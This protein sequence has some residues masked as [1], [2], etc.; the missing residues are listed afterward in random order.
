MRKAFYEFC[1]MNLAHSFAQNFQDLFALWVSRGSRSAYFVEFGALNGRDFSNTYL[2]EKLGWNGIV[3]EPNPAYTDKIASV[4]NCHISHDCVFEESG[5][6]VEFRQVL[7][8]AALSGIGKTELRDNKWEFRQNYKSIAIRTIS[9]NDLLAKYNA[10]KKIEF[11]SIDTE[12]SELS[13]L[14]SFDFSRWNVLS[15]CV[16][17]NSE[18]RDSI[19]SLM[20]EHGYTRVFEELSGHDDWWVRQQWDLSELP[21]IKKLSPE[22]TETFDK[23]LARRVRRL[24]TWHRSLNN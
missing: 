21:A 17:H 16:E 4:R 18:N 20:T 8:R 12:G 6:V 7:G 1:S 10:P 13:I 3:A 19:A 5:Q 14:S 9:L 24:N 22:I 23:N 2:L 15:F 11:I